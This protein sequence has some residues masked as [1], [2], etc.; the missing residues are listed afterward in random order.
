MQ[1]FLRLALCLALA[2]V[3][4]HVAQPSRVL[5]GEPKPT[6]EVLREALP[7]ALYTKAR[8]AVA[9]GRL[10]EAA[11]TFER[12]FLLSPEHRF[13]WNAGR[14]RE[15]MG[16]LE[17]AHRLYLLASTVAKDAATKAKDDDAIRAVEELLYKQGLGRLSIVPTP[18]DAAVTVDGILVGPVAGQ[19][20]RWLQPGDHRVEVDARG[21][22]ASVVT[23]RIAAGREFVHTISLSTSAQQPVGQ[24]GG[25]PIHV[26]T[27]ARR[28]GSWKTAGGLV[29]GG[30]A[31]VALGVGIGMLLKGAGASNDANAMPIQTLDQVKAYDKAYDDARSIWTL[32][33]VAGG[34][35]LAAAGAATWMLATAPREPSKSALVGLAPAAGGATAW[36]RV[37]F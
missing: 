14:L 30:V 11:E 13:A 18:G 20:I 16:E 8:K 35:G 3:L 36:V 37:A 27:K 9:A 32:G 6:P 2:T 15:R 26:D 24:A 23:L 29:T 22:T 34:V 5:A 19:R 1:P 25:A 33:A 12:A 17:H 7:E 31:V 10:V 21:Y 4:A 28:P